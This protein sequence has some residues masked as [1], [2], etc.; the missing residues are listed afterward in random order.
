MRILGIDYGEKRIGLAVS[1]EMQMLARELT[2]VSPKDFFV[3]LPSLLQ[4]YDIQTIAL[5]FPLNMAG[6]KT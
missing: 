5:G 3:R 4:E 2:I 6:E 1:D